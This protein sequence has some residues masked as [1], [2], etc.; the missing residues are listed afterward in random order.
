MVV[1]VG[2][3]CGGPASRGRTDVH[4][5]AAPAHGRLPRAGG[6]GSRPSAD[7]LVARLQLALPLHSAGDMAQPP[8]RQEALQFQ[9]VEVA[10][11]GDLVSQVLE[12]IALDP[13]VVRVGVRRCLRVV[14]LRRRSARAPGP[15]SR[16]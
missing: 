9:P 1:A 15:L 12:L 8:Q 3:G 14:R 2:K 16:A 13:V 11:G 4:R 7:R 6:R 10:C 5:S